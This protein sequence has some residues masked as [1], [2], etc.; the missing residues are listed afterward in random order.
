MYIFSLHGLYFEA[1]YGDHLV[2]QCDAKGVPQSAVL[3][4]A[5]G[6]KIEG[7]DQVTETAASSGSNG[8][9]NVDIPSSGSILSSAS[10]LRRLLLLRKKRQQTLVALPPSA[11]LEGAR[12]SSEKAATTLRS[13]VRA[14]VFCR[15]FLVDCIGSTT[16]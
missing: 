3:N 1:C 14:F 7:L 10:L 2:S 11:V 6:E 9:T 16:E 15:G 8:A 5:P 12:L 4:D 13:K